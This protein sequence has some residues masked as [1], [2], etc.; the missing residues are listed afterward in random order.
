MERAREVGETGGEA[1]HEGVLQSGSDTGEHK[2]KT[3][4]LEKD[5]HFQGQVCNHIC[6]CLHL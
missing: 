4:E 6:P 1:R 3:V 2:D 5:E